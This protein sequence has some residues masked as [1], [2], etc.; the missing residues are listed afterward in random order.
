NR[1]WRIDHIYL[2]PDLYAQAQGCEI[3][4]EPR[5]WE[6]PSDHTPVIVEV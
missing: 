3:D 1:G 2:T 5:K 4:V 6:R